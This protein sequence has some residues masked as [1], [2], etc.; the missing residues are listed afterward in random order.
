M[1]NTLHKIGR[2]SGEGLVFSVIVD[3]VS[4]DNRRTSVDDLFTGLIKSGCVALGS[5]ALN[6]EVVTMAKS[7]KYT[8]SLPSRSATALKRV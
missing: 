6:M 5:G 1:T 3:R 4:A 2:S 7:S 8:A